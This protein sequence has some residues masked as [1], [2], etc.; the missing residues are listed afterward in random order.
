MIIGNIRSNRAARCTGMLL[1]NFERPGPD[2]TEDLERAV[3]A[4]H[5]PGRWIRAAQGLQAQSKRAGLSP[6][7]IRARVY[8]WMLLYAAT[9]FVERSS[10]EHWLIR[11]Q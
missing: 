2:P 3:A 5:G 6:G 7:L 10:I 4:P 9:C 11:G 1:R 8:R